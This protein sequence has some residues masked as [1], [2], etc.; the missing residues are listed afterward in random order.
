MSTDPTCIFC[1]IIAGEIPS[2]RV[3][4][5]DHAVGFLDIGAW[6][7]GHTLVVPRRHVPDLLTGEPAMAEIGPAIDAVARLLADTLGADGLNLVSSTG[8]VAGQEVFHLHVH[9]IPRYAAEPG[10]ANLISP[11]PVSED[12]LDAVHAQITG[13]R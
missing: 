4:E 2:R 11:G 5:D 9:V 12:E 7:R 10:L 8:K 6:H 1:K 13:A 3:Y